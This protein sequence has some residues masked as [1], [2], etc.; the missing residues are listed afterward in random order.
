MLVFEA[1]DFKNMLSPSGGESLDRWHEYVSDGSDS[2]R[3][4]SPQHQLRLRWFIPPAKT[5]ISLPSLTALVASS[6]PAWLRRTFKTQR[7]HTASPSWSRNPESSSCGHSRVCNHGGWGKYLTRKCGQRRNTVATM[8][9]HLGF[10][11][12]HT[13]CLA[14][15]DCKWGHELKPL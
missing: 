15:W 14:A 2:V 6:E 10:N 1:Q 11:H 8:E 4:S 3:I 9:D 5:F 7:G 13:Q 12:T